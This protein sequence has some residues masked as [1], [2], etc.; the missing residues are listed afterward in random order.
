MVREV[1]AAGNSFS[2]IASNLAS[3]SA[4]NALA[5]IGSGGVAAM[6]SVTSSMDN[7]SRNVTI[8]ADFTGVRSADEIYKALTE[9]QNYNLQSLYA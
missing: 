8:N 1:V 2:G 3:I 7:S 6:N 4:S 5:Q 9:L